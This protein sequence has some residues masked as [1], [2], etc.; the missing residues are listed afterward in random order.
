[1][2][3]DASGG[4]VPATG[5][6]TDL[7]L[8]LFREGTHCRLYRKLGAH[9]C[10][11]DGT[12]GLRVALWA[13]HARAVSLVGD[14]NGWRADADPLAPRGDGSGIWDTFVAHVGPGAAY[15]FVVEPAD[16]G[17]SVE[18][19]DPF[20]F[21]AERP[22]GTASRVSALDHAWGDADWMA[23]RTAVAASA[24]PLAIYEVHLG[25]WR[26]VPEEGD[27]WLTYR[28]AAPLLVD[29]MRSLGFTHVE[30]LPLAEHPADGSLGYEATGYFAPT[31][32][33]GTPEDLVYL[34]DY[35]H[36]HGVGVIVDW[37]PWWFASDL[38]GLVRF[39]GTPLFEG[40]DEAREGGATGTAR[41]F[42]HGRA[43]VRSFL[44]SSALYW[45]DRFHV[46]GLRVAGRPTGREAAGTEFL[47]C[48][49]EAVRREHP[50][51][52]LIAGAPDLAARTGASPAR[53]G[54]GFDLVW[55][56]DWTAET[57]ACLGSEPAER[58]RHRRRLVG[59]ANRAGE[60]PRV[61]PLSHHE[62]APGRPSLVAR[63]PGDEW[64]RLATLRLLYGVLWAHPGKKLLFMGGEFAQLGGWNPERSLD[65]HLVQ[66]PAH[67]GVR[68]WV[69]D[70]N[71]VYR[72]EPALH[73]LD[74]T[75]EA[76]E[77]I[78]TEDPGSATMA[79]LRRGCSTDDRLLVVCN[80]GAEARSNHRLGV[81]R[82]GYWQ[83]ILNS[84]ARCYGGSGVGNL[85]GIEAAPVAAH[86]RFQSLSVHVPPLAA[87]FFKSSGRRA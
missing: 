41:R 74:G 20:A 7:D 30:F 48:L 52:L 15:R 11:R 37:V 5:A 63:F 68:S 8:H 77:W 13:P 22:P 60:S 25:S 72:A 79:F 70:L 32:R 42:D 9:P 51:A 23:R 3:G 71:R 27:R 69:A 59:A 16:G 87:L 10:R 86:G 75:P 44:L 81:P 84:D 18:K 39:D 76:I 78:E 47:R 62:V 36:R 49:T 83:E 4:I 58:S 66:F 45:L 54:R 85:G 34:V 31:A 43:E 6:M 56:R 73:E 40:A 33:Y 80:F 14:F 53:G 82:P 55:D 35:L 2:S 24:G 38:H 28:E 19:A 64:Q 1:M 50:G 21:A 17:A 57:L 12:P 65:W 46:D 26:R 29:H 61:L 67:G